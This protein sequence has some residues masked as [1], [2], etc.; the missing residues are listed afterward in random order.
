MARSEVVADGARALVIRRR[1]AGLPCLW[2]D[3]VPV[4]VAR[5]ISDSARSPDLSVFVRR[6]GDLLVIRSPSAA[7]GALQCVV[8]SC[9]WAPR[10]SDCWSLRRGS[11]TDAGCAAGRLLALVLP[12]DGPA[13]EGFADVVHDV[14]RPVLQHPV[15][16]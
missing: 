16:P 4:L 5:R 13:H 11:G 10:V 2:A 8:W 14:G 12:V 3:D 7:W 1:C 15:V 6:C 9:L